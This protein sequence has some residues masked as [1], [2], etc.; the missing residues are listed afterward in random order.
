VSLPRALFELVI[1]AL[2]PALLRRALHLLP[3]TR[4]AVPI[5]GF[6]ELEIPRRAVQSACRG[7]SFTTGR[8][9]HAGGLH[10]P[11]YRGEERHRLDRL[12]ELGVVARGPRAARHPR[13]G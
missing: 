6:L 13:P 1:R 5:R 8:R 2:A 9:L 4:D 3:V 10:E 12:R 7:S 11:R